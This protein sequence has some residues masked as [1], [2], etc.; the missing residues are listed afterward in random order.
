[1]KPWVLL[2]AYHTVN[3]SHGAIEWLLL[4]N[5]MV[6]SRRTVDLVPL[7]KFCQ[8]ETYAMKFPFQLARRIP[9][10]SWKTKTDAWNGYHSVPL[11]TSDRHLTTFN[12]PFGHWQYTRAPRGF[13]SSRD[14]YNRRF[15]AILAEIVRKE[16]CV[17]DTI[18]YDSGV[19]Q[20]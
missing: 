2:S 19:E 12:T 13:L 4:G 9:K 5:M 11:R 10:D 7:N 3:R 1:M 8:R 14:G 16:R 17:D 15:D 6:P 18:H 20:H